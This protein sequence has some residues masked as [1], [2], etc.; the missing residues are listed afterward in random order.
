M[1]EQDLKELI[2][3]VKKAKAEFQ[4]VE[5]KKCK[6]GVTERLFDTLSSFSNQDD[7]GVIIFGIDESSNYEITGIDDVQ[8]LQK[9]VMEQCQQMEPAV[10][11]VFTVT[12]ADGR[13]IVA[14]EIPPVDITERPCFYKGKGRIKG[15]YVRVGDAD[16]PMNE[17]EVYSYEAYRK[18]YQDEIREVER[19][20][21]SSLDAGPGA[22]E[23]QKRRTPDVG[24][25]AA[26]RLLSAGVFYAARDNCCIG[27]GNGDRRNRY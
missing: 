27:T 12:E 8:L 2:E 24:S 1:F 16:I 20:E 15:S 14:A 21:M 13:N 26:F 10:R 18:K 5:L 19:A 22:Y 3:K 9:K 4:N 25:R 6:D 7:G 23:H 11:A 17:Y